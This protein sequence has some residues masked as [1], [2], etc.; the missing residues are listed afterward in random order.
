MTTYATV[1]MQRIQTHLARCRHLWGRRGASEE[2]AHL[3]KLPSREEQDASADDDL[4]VTQV[5]S[6]YPDVE[7]NPEGLDIDG[8]VSLRSKQGG[9]QKVK[10]A[11][12]TLAQIIRERLPGITVT[13]RHTESTDSY[14]MVAQNEDAWESETWYPA[15]TEFPVARLCCECYRDPAAGTYEDHADADAG[16]TSREVR[17]CVDCGTRHGEAERWR[18]SN[19]EAHTVDAAPGSTSVFPNRFT[20]EGWLLRE[21]RGTE[22]HGDI[23][24]AKDFEALGRIGPIDKDPDENRQRRGRTHE[25]NHTALI[26]ADGN[27]MGGLFKKLMQE[28]ANSTPNGDSTK[29]VRDISKKIKQAT[30]DALLTATK[31]ILTKNDSI[32]PVVPHIN[33]GDDVLIS[34]TAPRAWQFIRSFLSELEKPF[35]D[36]E[37]E[38]GH[39]VSMS[40]GIV[41]CKAE[42]PF[43]TQVE[44]AESL[45]RR[46]KKAVHGEGWS[47]AWLDVTH[48]GIN[49]DEHQPWLLDD[50]TKRTDALD[51]LRGVITAHGETALLRALNAE[52]GDD[53]RLIHLSR[54]MSDIKD[55][56]GLLPETKEINKKEEQMRLI[57]ELVS[58]GR[59]WR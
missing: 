33:G 38:C 7:I 4:A 23:T 19:M 41:I 39:P 46:A 31:K 43:S 14:A 44:L 20:A 57:S 13:V 32:C 49:T 11:A 15:A 48:D 21:L 35:D 45:M 12:D 18:K 6:K 34:V 56:L 24:F 22:E 27:G 42:Y 17:L 59:W 55:F 50:L 25:G 30:A 10:E 29:K 58:I 3:T 26:F 52:S 54:R 47:F 5:L 16:S 40:A 36:I 2:L 8:V 9:E 51:H 1:G 53:L 28:A 37:K